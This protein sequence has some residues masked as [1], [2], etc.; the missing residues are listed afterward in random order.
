MAFQKAKR[1]AKKI[2]IAVAG[3]TGAGKTLG[4]L[5]MA[6]GLCKDWSKVFVIDTDSMA[7]NYADD[8]SWDIGEFMVDV[9]DPPYT[10]ERYMERMKEAE[11]MGA[12]VIIV[13]SFSEEH[14][15]EGGL[16]EMHSKMKGNSF[17]NWGPLGRRHNALLRYIV[18]EAKCH[19]I[20]TLK[21]KLS[22]EIVTNVDDR[23]RSKSGVQMIGFKPITKPETEYNFQLF[24]MLERETRLADVL[25]MR[26]S[27]LPNTNPVELTQDLGERL[28]LWADS[29]EALSQDLIERAMN[30]AGE[31]SDESIVSIVEQAIATQKMPGTSEY[32]TDDRLKNEF[33][34]RL[35]AKL[36]AEADAAKPKEEPAEPVE[37]VE[38][39]AE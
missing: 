30:L 11:K 2:R 7:N 33:I 1:L 18:H 21:S 38:S 23:G 24:L 34:P 36:Q 4:A 15:G 9:L 29:G 5:R 19:I 27:M 10:P 6:H 26:G 22:Y 39:E 20:C 3:P 25:T 12:E 8:T 37:S 16:I 32:L 35:E 17:V 14:A 13:D 28:S 31:S